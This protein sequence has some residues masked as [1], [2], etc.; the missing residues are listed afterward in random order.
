MYEN[1]RIVEIFENWWL[2]ECIYPDWYPEGIIPS[3]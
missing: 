3:L 1:N 2:G